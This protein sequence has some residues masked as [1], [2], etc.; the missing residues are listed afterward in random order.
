[1]IAGLI[2]LVLEAAI[3]LINLFIKNAERNRE[4]KDKM[5]KMIEKH[6]SAVMKNVSL[7]RDLE[8]LRADIKKHNEDMKNGL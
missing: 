6:S 1:M 3:P 7:R 5:F 8:D 4:M 2:T